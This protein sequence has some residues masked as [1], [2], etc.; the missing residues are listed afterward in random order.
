MRQRPSLMALPAISGILTLIVAAIVLGPL[1]FDLE[2]HHSELRV[3]AAVVV[4]AYPFAFLSV[5]FNVA[6]YA[7]ADATM[8]GRQMSLGEAL[9]FATTRLRAIAMW[10]LVTT[11]VGV[12]LRLLE[13]LPGA[14]GLAVRIAE[15][16]A[17]AAWA[18]AS[19]FVVPALA[20]EDIG[21]RDALKQSVGTIKRK[22]GES[23]TGAAVISVISSFAA[24][25]LIVLG[26][27]GV[28]VYSG[29]G[30]AAGVV[31]I[32]LA[33]IGLLAVYIA[34]TAVSQVFRLAVFQ[35]ARS[36]EPAGPFTAGELESAFQPKKNRFQ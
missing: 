32:A 9:R 2:D 15:I 19:Y 35:Y 3:I 17:N 7:L 13:Q 28:T 31:L 14:G 6:F 29:G 24:V 30:T 23:V 5:F 1:V 22:W 4:C 33:A 36:G 20:V 10:S 11:V 26:V 16:V 21:V 12:V 18:I 25:P 34:Q 27:I 8:N